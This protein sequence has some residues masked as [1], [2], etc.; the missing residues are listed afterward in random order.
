M[1]QALAPPDRS[2]DLAAYADK[3]YMVL[4]PESTLGVL[5]F[6]EVWQFR[7]LLFGLASRDVKL[8]YRQTFLGV[9]WV[10][11][12][13][14]AAAG[15]FSIVFGVIAGLKGTAAVPYFVFSYAGMMAWNVFSSTLGK[16][17]GCLVGNAGLVS[18]VYFPRLILPLS[19]VL[20]TLIDFSVSLCVMAVLLAIFRAPVG[21]GVLL[22]PVWL[23]ALV[24]LALGV[25]LFTS[26][27]MVSYRDVGHILPVATNLLLYLSPI[28]FSLAAAQ[29]KL[30]PKLS[31]LI[32]LNP[33][34]GLLEA[35]RWSL[36]VAPVDV[37]GQPYALPLGLLAYSLLLAA[38]LFVAGA[39][40]FWK[41]ERRFADVI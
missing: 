8:R 39:A 38:G 12:Q 10:L 3:P 16:A 41:V 4:R 26:A 1:T 23:G 2:A 18:K 15:I 9:A 6:A 30:G 14:L 32:W 35:V 20:S 21:V 11:L 31:W 37:G 33:L 28:A 7:D 25:G 34:T 17:S 24:V 22:L 13:P 27:A 29:D 40:Y 5:N 36:G 19:T